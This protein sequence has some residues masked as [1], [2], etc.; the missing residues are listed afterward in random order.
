MDHNLRI[1]ILLYKHVSPSKSTLWHMDQHGLKSVYTSVWSGS[2]FFAYR[3][4]KTRVESIALVASVDSGET[5]QKC[6]MTWVYA[7]C[8]CHKVG[9][10]V[11]WPAMTQ[12]I[13]CPPVENLGT[14][15]VKYILKNTAQAAVYQKSM[16]VLNYWLAVH[17][18]GIV[19]WFLCLIRMTAYEE[20]LKIKGHGVKDDVKPIDSRLHWKKKWWK[21]DWLTNANVLVVKAW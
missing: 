7:G 16:M 12:P 3:I 5:A 1:Y 13:R 14:Y 4:F 9:A 18:I 19:M 20:K 17:R 10:C 11:I 21:N 15:L 6:R 2:T 8:I